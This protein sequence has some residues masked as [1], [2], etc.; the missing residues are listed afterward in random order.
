MAIDIPVRFIATHPGPRPGRGTS[1]FTELAARHPG[2][3]SDA[4]ALRLLLDQ[5]PCRAGRVRR[6][7]H[8]IHLARRH[9]V[10]ARRR[11]RL[12]GA[13]HP[14]RVP[15]PRRRPPPDL[16]LGQL[17]RLDQPDRRR[18]LRRDELRLV[19]AQAHPP[20]RE[21]EQGG[22]RPRPRTARRLVHARAGDSAPQPA[23][24]LGRSRT[25]GC[26]SSRSCCSRASR[27][28]R[29][30]C[31]GCFAA[32]ARRPSLGRDRV[33]GRALRRIPRPSSSSCSHPASRS[34]SSASSSGCSA[35][36]W[37]RRSRRTTRGCR[38]SRRTCKLDF[39]RRQ[40]MMS[41]NIRGSRMLDIAMGG[42]NYQIEHHL[43]PSMP[44]PHLRRAAPIIAR[45]LPRARRA[46]HAR[47]DSSS[48][49]GSCCATSTGSDSANGTR[50]TARWSRSGRASDC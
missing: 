37:G 11:R 36:T 27:C 44:R 49:T 38:S 22:R 30:A 15:R 19:A 34:R 45:L 6:R 13:V 46:V 16:Q 18:P 5:D 41:R 20:P 48:R 21:P 12:R 4:P 23:D 17:E 8:R 2:V 25:R 43:F 33:P 26:S 28:T 1:D 14:D 3:R 47:P 10:A 24:R 9:L 32:R 29:R 31:A 35:S 42:L 7:D 50:S 40:V 39:L